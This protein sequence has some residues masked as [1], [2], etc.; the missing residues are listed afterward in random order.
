MISFQC[1]HYPGIIIKKTQNIIIMPITY[2]TQKHRYRQF[3]G[4]V[5]TGINHIINISFKFKPG[6]AVRNNRTG[7]EHFAAEIYLAVKIDAGRTHQLADDHTL[8][9]VNNKRPV[10]CH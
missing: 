8:R 3:A 5:H 6:T 10:F 4:T 2:G 9:P 1:G 7:K